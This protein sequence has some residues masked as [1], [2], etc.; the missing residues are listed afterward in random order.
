MDPIAL[1]DALKSKTIAAAALDVTSPEP[2]DP[3][4]PLLSLENLVVAPH[5]GSSTVTTR[6]RMAVLAAQNLVAGLEGRPLPRLRQPPSLRL[7]RP[8]TGS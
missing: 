2:I 7:T 5:L 6:T 3:N 4:D 1:Y 8:C